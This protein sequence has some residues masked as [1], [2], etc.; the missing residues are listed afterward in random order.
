MQGDVEVILLREEVLELPAGSPNYSNPRPDSQ[1]TGNDG[2]TGPVG[3]DVEDPEAMETMK[4]STIAKKV[5]GGYN[6]NGTK[7][8]I[9]NGSLANYVITTIPTDHLNPKESMATFLIPSSSKGFKVGRIERKCGQKVSQTAELF[10]NDLFVPEENVWEPPGRGLR[11]TREILSI[12]RGYIGLAGL[13][14]ARGSLER[15]VQYAYQKKTGSHRLIDEDWVKIAIAD[16]LK[17]IMAVR[18]TC[19]DFAIAM[20]TYHVWSLF[21]KLPVKAALNVLPGK[22]LLSD[23]L[24]QIANHKI[25][26]EIGSKYKHSLITDDLIENFIKIGSAAKVAGTDLAMKVSSRV[27]DIVGL[28]GMS[29]KYGIEKYFR[30][31]KITQIYEGTNQANRI[32]LFNNEIGRLCH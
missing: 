22:L 8:F 19:F 18:S 4:P 23:S 9:T 6:I 16:M 15:C 21:E 26:D 14:L 11:H 32:D 28:E 1:D 2:A 17:D 25:I 20:D 5:Q 13:G 10:F 31:A 30:D 12:T 29:Y 24:L 7:C 3:T 27:L